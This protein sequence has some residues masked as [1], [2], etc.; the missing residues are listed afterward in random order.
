M[1]WNKLYWIHAERWSPAISLAVSSSCARNSSRLCC[2]NAGLSGVSDLT[3]Y[4]KQTNS[5]I[6][7]SYTASY[8]EQWSHRLVLLP[9][10]QMRTV[11]FVRQPFLSFA[12]NFVYRILM[13]LLQ[14]A[15]HKHHITSLLSR[16]DLYCA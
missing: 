1:A 8:K 6:F 12:M 15:L 9:K 11:L 3:P 13:V 7:K 2:T 4:F 5:V 16:L 10:V 14:H